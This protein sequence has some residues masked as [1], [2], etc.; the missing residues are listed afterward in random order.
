ME[1]V[2][3]HARVKAY[4]FEKF[5]LAKNMKLEDHALL[6]ENGIIDSLGI[7]DLVSYLEQ[8]F[9]ITVADEE[10]DPANFRSIMNI[11]AYVRDKLVAGVGKRA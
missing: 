9:G 7:L 1:M 6:L 8:E 3:V 5:P 10:M 2:D 4:I 11:A